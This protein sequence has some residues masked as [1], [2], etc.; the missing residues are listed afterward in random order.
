VLTI[1]ET[2][3]WSFVIQ[4]FRNGLPWLRRKTFEV[5]TSTYP[6]GITSSRISDQQRDIYS[7]CRCC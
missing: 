2:Y 1:S 6:I 5:M 3:A 4:I 7:I